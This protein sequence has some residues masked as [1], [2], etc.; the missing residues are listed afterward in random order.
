MA[1]ASPALA[2][3]ATSGLVS[4]RA[5]AVPARSQTTW[6]T[7]IIAARRAVLAM[8]VGG[9]IG[10]DAIGGEDRGDGDIGLGIG[11]AEH[12]AAPQRRR[13]ARRIERG[14]RRRGGDLPGEV[15]HIGDR[16]DGERRPDRRQRQERR[17][18]AQRHD[19]ENAGGAGDEADHIG[20][21]AGDAEGAAD[22]GD[23][24]RR[25]AGAAHH[26]ERGEE[27]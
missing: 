16:R 1:A 27:Q 4:R 10:G 22:R 7:T 11:D 15:D 19:D 23:A 13:G 6:M 2:M 5:K 8:R 17:A 25:R 9:R 12:D 3:R 21:G 14:E 24:D 20:D 18:Q 26:R